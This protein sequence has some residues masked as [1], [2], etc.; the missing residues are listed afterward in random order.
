MLK[1]FR[2]NG[3]IM[4][5]LQKLQIYFKQILIIIAHTRL[6]KLINQKKERKLKWQIN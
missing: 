2:W 4:S 3:I 6:S 1:G 5:L